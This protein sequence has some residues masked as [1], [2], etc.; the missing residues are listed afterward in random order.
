MATYS[1]TTGN[2][3]TDWGRML[4]RSAREAA[5]PLVWT[6]LA[7]LAVSLPTLGL[8]LLDERLFQGVSVWLKPWK[9]QVSVGVFLLTLALFMGWLPRAALRSRAAKYVVWAA[10]CS[11]LFEVA[12]ISL[13]GAQGLAS[14]FNTATRLSALLYQLMGLGAVTLSST[15]LV[16]GLLVARSTGYALA[17]ALKLSIVL[18]LVLTFLLGTGFGAYLSAQPSGHWV[19]G[20]LSDAG[21][22]PLVKWSRDGGDL[23]VAHFFGIHAMHFIPAFGLAVHRLRLANSAERVAVWMFAAAFAA[24][25]AWTFS[26][27]L[28]GGPLIH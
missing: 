9:F 4:A 16:L 7:L 5:P 18:G 6:G 17:G 25:S 2:A 19:G 23:R 15:A 20:S 13:Q 24:F 11:G 27:A 8:A 21:G 3:R 28:A 14:H 10:V 26:Q 22:L 12:Y 1:T